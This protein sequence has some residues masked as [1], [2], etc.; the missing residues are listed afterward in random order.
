MA[1]LLAGDIAWALWAWYLLNCPLPPTFHFGKAR[2]LKYEIF[3]FKSLL[4]LPLRSLD[5]LCTGIQT[6]E[7][8]GVISKLLSLITLVMLCEFH[9]RF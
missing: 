9:G 1:L 5:L 4:S 6:L 7:V 3:F 2:L 8:V